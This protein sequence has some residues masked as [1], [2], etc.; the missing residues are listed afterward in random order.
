VKNAEYVRRFDSSD[1]PQQRI[2]KEIGMKG[3]A[4]PTDIVLIA[5]NMVRR[6][7]LVGI[8]SNDPVRNCDFGIIG[9]EFN[10][11]TIINKAPQAYQLIGS[12]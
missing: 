3:K 9:V 2:S 12:K 1:L 5:Q 7:N 11:M 8:L 10:S 4:A 6:P